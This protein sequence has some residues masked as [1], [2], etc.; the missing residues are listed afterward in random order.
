MR[1]NWMLI[2]GCGLE[3]GDELGQCP[4][5]DETRTDEFAFKV[6]KVMVGDVATSGSHVP[7]A[8]Y[9]VMHLCGVGIAYECKLQTEI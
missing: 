4:V 3:S 9:E 7:S 5:G 8:I 1:G 2:L 6:I